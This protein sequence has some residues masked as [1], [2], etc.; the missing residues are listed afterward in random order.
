MSYTPTAKDFPYPAHAHIIPS[1]D[2]SGERAAKL[3]H[4]L[5]GLPWCEQG[6][7]AA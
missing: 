1:Y 4:T 2:E 5:I 6:R 7:H 3:Y